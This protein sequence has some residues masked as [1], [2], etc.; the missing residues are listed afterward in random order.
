LIVRHKQSAH[1]FKF[2][3]RKRTCFSYLRIKK[4]EMGGACSTYGRE[5]YEVSVG[6]IERKRELARWK[7]NIKT[8]RIGAWIELIWLGTGTNGGFV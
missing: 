5:A 6:K 1:R 8:D 3:L 2:F 7:D 4:N